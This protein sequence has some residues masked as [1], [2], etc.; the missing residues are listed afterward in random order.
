MDLL[1]RMKREA[2]LT[3]TARGR[4]RTRQPSALLIPA[5]TSHL[6]ADVDTHLEATVA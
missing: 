6:T 2:I 5:V 3:N 4:L 1:R